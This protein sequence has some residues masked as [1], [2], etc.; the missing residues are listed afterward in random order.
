MTAISSVLGLFLVSFVA[1][2]LLPA[3]SE[4]GVA[5]LLVADAAPVWLLIL[6]ASTGNTLGS[7]VNWFL[8][9]GV[10]RFSSRRWFPVTPSQ[11]DRA[12]A[13]YQRWGKWSLLL[14]WAPVIGD[15]LTLAA[16]VLREPFLPFLLLVALAKTVRYLVIAALVLW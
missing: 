15:P 4:L 5:G 12:S 6:V 11:L 8:G 9:R 10:A 16:G 7:V 3:Q 1:A 2:T 14:S 13:W